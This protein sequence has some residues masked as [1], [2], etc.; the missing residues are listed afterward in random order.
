MD[1]IAT[2]ALSRGRQVGNFVRHFFEMCVAMCVGGGLLNALIFVAGPT[3]VGYPDLREKTP[4]P[5]L[6]MI[7]FVYTLPMTAWMRFRGMEWRPVLEMSGATVGLALL[8]IGLA[9]FG[10]ISE[11]DLRASALGFCGPACVVMFPVMLFR[12]RLY[13]G[14][15][16][17]HMDRPPHGTA[18]AGAPVT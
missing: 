5:A 14:R 9:G 3:L 17:H 15:T 11:S 10:S 8:L 18:D 12:L 16:G 7:A 13:T 2:R 6:L 1:H 4:E